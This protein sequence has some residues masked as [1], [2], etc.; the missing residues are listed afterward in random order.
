MVQKPVYI[1]LLRPDDYDQFRECDPALPAL[2]PH[3]LEGFT[4]RVTALKRRGAT[5]VSYPIE[6]ADFATWGKILHVPSLNEEARDQYA[7]DQAAAEAI[8]RHL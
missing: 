2:Y 3:W 8:S 1:A 4:G 5:V 7:A 6:F